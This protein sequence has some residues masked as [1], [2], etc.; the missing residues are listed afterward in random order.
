MSKQNYTFFFKDGYFVTFSMENY[1]YQAI[2]LAISNKH[3]FVM[4]ENYIIML[5][6][7]RYIA[8][9]QEVEVQS[10]AVPEEVEQDVYEYLKYLER[11]MKD[12]EAKE[13]Y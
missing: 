4:L 6:D 13:G 2:K 8:K 9:Q 5:S 3:E 11:E 12:G 10:S 7:I 1:E